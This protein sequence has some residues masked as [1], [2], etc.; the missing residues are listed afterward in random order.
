MHMSRLVTDILF[1]FLQDFKKIE[2]CSNNVNSSFSAIAS[3]AAMGA[4][5]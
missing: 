3:L 2:N 1:L 4:V 5:G